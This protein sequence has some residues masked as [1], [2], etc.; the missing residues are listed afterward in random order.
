MIRTQINREG[1][2][3]NKINSQSG[4]SQE[5][6]DYEKN[7]NQEGEINSQEPYTK[8]EIKNWKT[9]QI[10]NRKIWKEIVREARTHR[11]L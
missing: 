3:S 9:K 7:P 11:E 8:M 4:R 10:R 2:R 1:K 5:K 6:R